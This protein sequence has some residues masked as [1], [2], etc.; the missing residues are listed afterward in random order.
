VKADQRDRLGQLLEEMDAEAGPVPPGV[1]DAARQIW[2]ERRG[3]IRCEEELSNVRAV[4]TDR[5]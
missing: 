2:A 4:T 3:R 1:L 5:A